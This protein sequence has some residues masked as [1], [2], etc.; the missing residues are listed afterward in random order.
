MPTTKKTTKKR[1]MH[2]NKANERRRKTGDEDVE[3]ILA[4]TEDDGDGEEED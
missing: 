3:D 1:A 4:D 2:K